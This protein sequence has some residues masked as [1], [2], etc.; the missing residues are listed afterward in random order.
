MAAASENS[1]ALKLLLDADADVNFKSTQGDTALAWAH[2]ASIVRLLK[3]YGGECVC[4]SYACRAQKFH[5]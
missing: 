2:D 4:V 3:E 1:Q 5:C